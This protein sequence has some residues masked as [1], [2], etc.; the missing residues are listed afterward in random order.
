M[1]VEFLNRYNFNF[2]TITAI[3]DNCATIIVSN[4][5]SL[6]LEELKPTT[7]SSIVTEGGTNHKS[8]HIGMAKVF[9]Y[10]VDENLKEILLWDALYFPTSPINIIS[11]G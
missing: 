8:N 5:K 7:S 11:I 1:L 4:G 2:S 9:V 10:N 6:F 3:V